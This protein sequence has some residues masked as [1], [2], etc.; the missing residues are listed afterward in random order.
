MESRDFRQFLKINYYKDLSPITL[1]NVPAGFRF[2]PS[3]GRSCF[4]T[5]ASNLAK[6]VISHLQCF[7]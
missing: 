1:K 7:V 5:L 6:A 2:S 3:L 4:S